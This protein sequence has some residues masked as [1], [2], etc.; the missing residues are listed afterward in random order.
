MGRVAGVFD[1]QYIKADKCVVHNVCIEC[2][3]TQKAHMQI[4]AVPV[5]QNRSE[6][7]FS[8]V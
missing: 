1:N 7:V 5:H 4:K 8:S 6:H 3:L 2:A